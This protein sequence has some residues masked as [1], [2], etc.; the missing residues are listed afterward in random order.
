MTKAKN[1]GLQNLP[2][3]AV[4][5]IELVIKKMRYR[6]KVRA[7]VMSEL[8]AHFEDELQDCKTDEEKDAKS[9]QLIEEFGDARL[10]AVLLRRGK[11]R[12][13]S[14]KRKFLVHTFQMLGVIV[15]YVMIRVIFLMLGS[16]NINIDYVD[17]LNDLVRVNRPEKENAQS[18]YSKAVELYVE[19]PPAIEKKRI[20]SSSTR[21]LSDFNDLEMKC[22]SKWLIDNQP[23]F[24]MLRQGT[25]KPYYWLTYD[26]DD[27]ELINS[28][29]LQNP[30]IKLRG[31]AYW[32]AAVMHNILKPQAGYR[33]VARAIADKILY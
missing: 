9:R 13:R 3:C 33:K 12:C 14:L 23:V 22:L 27:T 20:Y 7:E 32:Q 1:S 21:W 17:W 26:S 19:R 2:A 11:K 25:L 6:K 28:G 8:T 29:V 16:P 31:A 15:L 10:L 5:F 30:G 4:E 24:E 18:Y